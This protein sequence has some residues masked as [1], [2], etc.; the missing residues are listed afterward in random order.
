M[1]LLLE[2]QHLIL[3]IPV[4]SF[5]YLY[6][7]KGRNIV[8]DINKLVVKQDSFFLLGSIIILSIGFFSVLMYI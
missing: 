7:K 5:V 3:L 8:F 6:F 2:V 1:V 4:I